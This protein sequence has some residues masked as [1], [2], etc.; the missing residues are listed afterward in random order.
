[1][2]RRG[3]TSSHASP[4]PGVVLG[5]LVGVGVGAAQFLGHRAHRCPEPPHAAQFFQYDRV[6]PPLVSV[7][8]E[9]REPPQAPQVCGAWKHVIARAVMPVRSMTDRLPGFV[10]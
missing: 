8:V 3:A 5:P 7:T 1:V 2:W 9:P 10:R 6:T 4:G